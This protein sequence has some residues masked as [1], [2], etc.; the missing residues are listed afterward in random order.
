MR[1]TNKML[2]NNFLR[3]MRTNLNN[4]QTLQSQLS[5]GK[6]IRKPSD[7]PFKVARSMQLHSDIAENKQ[8]NENIK[9]TLNN[10]DST[11]TAL[12]QATN[13]FQ[14]MRE[15]LI[16]AGNAAY[17]SD[18]RKAI[19][20]EFN[21]KVQELSQVLNTNFDGSYIFGGTK[22]SS[23]PLTTYT[24]AN[25]NSILAYS[26]KEGNVLDPSKDADSAN[27]MNM[28]GQKI[29]VEISQGVTMEYNVTA[30]DVLNFK[31]TDNNVS[32]LL[33]H[34]VENLDSDDKA[35]KDKLTGDNLTD[36]TTVMSNLLKV[37]AEVGAKQNRMEAA[38]SKNEDE[39][40]NMTDILSKTEDIDITQKM[41]EYSTMQTV[42]T[43]S[44]QTS[45]KVIQPTLM[46]YLR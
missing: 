16:S 35:N 6:E 3:D 39:N 32:D 5:S 1:V 8:Y 27:Q 33:K 14:R 20:D 34:I 21:Q 7:N 30:T 45:A 25:G 43:A 37:R 46:D 19:K 10:L 36:I 28:I 41:M 26:D 29:K 2:S 13:V 44:L 12:G 15:L 11:D 40:F 38:Q 31:G 23:K 24:D 18:E 4:I 22:A 9:D 42:Y 17:G